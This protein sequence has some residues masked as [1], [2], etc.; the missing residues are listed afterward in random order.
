MSDKL[1]EKTRAL[2]DKLRY[3]SQGALEYSEMAQVMAESLAANAYIIDC[4]GRVS[5]Y[6]IQCPPGCTVLLQT[7]QA[8]PVLPWKYR[9]YLAGVRATLTRTAVTLREGDCSVDGVACRCKTTNACLIPVFGGS[10]RYGTLVL[11]R[12]TGPFDEEDIFIV[13]AAVIA[14]SNELLN[15][16]KEQQAKE[17]RQREAVKKAIDVLSYSELEVLALIL[18]KLVNGEGVLVGR[19]LA[20]QIGFNRSVV[21]SAVRKLSSAGLLVSQSLGMKGTH[22]RVLNGYL[23]DYVKDLGWENL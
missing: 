8:S 6:S 18:K 7:G 12:S 14:V 10:K 16:W 1:L 17:Y 11:A 19:D 2:N 3:L 13:E 15:R 9:R 23:F 4:H 22:L 21:V 5:G 20:Q